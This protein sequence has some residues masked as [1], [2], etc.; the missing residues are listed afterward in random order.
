MSLPEHN[1]GGMEF[2]E[3]SCVCTVLKWLLCHPMINLI[4]ILL[5]RN[6][7][8]LSEEAHHSFSTLATIP[9]DD[10]DDDNVGFHNDDKHNNEHGDD[11]NGED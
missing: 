8:Q 10:D 5:L 6:I 4:K 2:E 11:D 9:D 3:M 1:L 7:E